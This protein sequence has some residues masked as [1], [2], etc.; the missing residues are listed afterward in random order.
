MLATGFV[1]AASVAAVR[2]SPAEK[3]MLFRV[4][5]SHGATIYLLGSVHLL[6]P[7]AAKLPAAVDSAFACARFV[8]FETSLDSLQAHGMELLALARNAPGTTLRSQLTPAGA[9]KADSLLKAYGASVDQF[10]PFKPWF[11]T[12]FMT[13]RAIQLAKFQAELGVDAQ[14][15]ARAHEANKPV[16]GL[17]SVDFQL[18]LFDSFT[19]AEQEQMLLSTSSPDSSA[20]NLVSIKDAWLTGNTAK[21][22]SVLNKSTKESPSLFEKLVVA[23]NKSWIPRL[24]SMLQGSDDGLVVVGAAHLV[25]AQ[26]VLAMLKA[27]GYSI[28]Q[29]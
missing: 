13:Q 21:L 22:D 26:G 9:A 24:D 27:K 14:I 11:V 2:P 8:A 7:D 1:I 15:N 28:E 20:A 18:H 12:L 19:P 16:T 23:R 4:R 29:L 10:A 6:S 5:G 25:G 3:H 17:E